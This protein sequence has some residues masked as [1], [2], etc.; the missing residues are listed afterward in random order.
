MPFDNRSY[1]KALFGFKGGVAGAA[2]RRSSE[3][4]PAKTPAPSPAALPDDLMR[5]LDQ[6]EREILVR[7][8]ER[9]RY[10]RAPPPAPTWA[11]R[12]ARCVTAWHVW[13]S[14]TATASAITRASNARA[15]WVPK[16]RPGNGARK[17]RKSTARAGAKRLRGAS[18]KRHAWQRPMRAPRALRG[19]EIARSRRTGAIREVTTSTLAVVAC[20]GR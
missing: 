16:P 1:P 6:L 14:P 7:A 13:A 9:Y 4:A 19:A 18:R 10:N 17:R 8:L 2:A 5:H 15:P 12:C 11:C 20:E 3:V